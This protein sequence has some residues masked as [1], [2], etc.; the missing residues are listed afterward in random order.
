MKP[1]EVDSEL[2]AV[3]PRPM[4]NVEGSMLYDSKSKD[5]LEKNVQTLDASLFLIE[6]SLG[7]SQTPIRIEMVKRSL[8]MDEFR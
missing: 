8:G 3:V 1:S 5:M 2:L 4:L 7:G 6:M